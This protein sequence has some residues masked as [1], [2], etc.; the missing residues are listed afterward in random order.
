MNV[1]QCWINFSFFFSFFVLRQSLNTLS[2]LALSFSVLD[3][4]WAHPPPS[5]SPGEGITGP[6]HQ[7][8]LSNHGAVQWHTVFLQAF[9]VRRTS[10]NPGWGASV[11]THVHACSFPLDQQVSTQDEPAPSQGSAETIRKHRYCIMTHDSSKGSN[12]AI[13]WLGISI[14]WGTVLKSQH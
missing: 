8:Q 14:A 5:A 10:E 11:H 9:R 7:T 12:K 2:I 4:N 13:S 3:R 1:N 6:Q